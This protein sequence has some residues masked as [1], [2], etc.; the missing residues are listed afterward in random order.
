MDVPSGSV[1]VKIYK[2]RNKAYHRKSKTGRVVESKRFGYT[3]SYFAGGKRWQKMFADFDEAYRSAKSKAD[4]LSAG[5]LDALELGAAEARAYVNC[6]MMAKV[7]GLELEV[8]VKD[9]VEAWTS[10]GGRATVP[11]AA[12]EYAQRHHHTQPKKTVPQA[13]EEMIALREKDGTSDAY[14]KVLKVYLGQF[15]EKFGNNLTSLTSTMMTDYFR[16]LPVSARSKNNARAT[17]GAFLKFCKQSGWLPRDHEG[18]TNVPKFKERASEVIEIYSPKELVEILTVAREEMIPFLT[19]GAFAG[20][21]TAE[22]ERLD[23]SEVQLKDKEPFIE[24]KA[25]KAKTASRRLVPVSENLAQWLKPHR[26]EHGR[27]WDFKNSAKQIAWLMEDLSEVRA[28]AAIHKAVER[29]GR[30]DST[31]HP[32]PLPGRGGEGA[33]KRKGWTQDEL[34]AAHK[35]RRKLERKAFAERQAKAK[36]EGHKAPEEPLEQVTALPDGTEVT[37]QRAEWRKNALRHSFIS[38]RLAEIHD[39][40]KVALEAGN[41]PQ[42][43]FQHYRELVR[44]DDARKWFGI[45][46]DG[47]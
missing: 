43:I 21:R 6:V 29:L 16:T 11:E 17:V 7:T 34:D 36:A 42:I 19:L 37:Y 47:K 12:R 20:L 38:Y 31:P 14:L 40:A 25:S 46:P 41:S 5:E 45:L 10:L 28:M 39:V 23:W 22:I 2:V 15:K 30:G 27:V 1:T 24:I 35:A 3:V 8:L 9:Y 33:R 18:V 44:P 4:T 26:K 13:V 32:S